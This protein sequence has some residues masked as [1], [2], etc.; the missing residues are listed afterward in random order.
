M[1]L[2]LPVGS[3]NPSGGLS[4][5]PVH[6]CA[7]FFVYMNDFHFFFSRF[8]RDGIKHIDEDVRLRE[9]VL[10]YLYFSADLLKHFLFFIFG[11]CFFNFLSISDKD[12]ISTFL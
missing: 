8:S 12:F 5:L 11:H 4:L 7:G 1:I 9:S 2:T 3:V 6:L 10:E